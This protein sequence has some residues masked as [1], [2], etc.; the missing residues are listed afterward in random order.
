MDDESGELF[1]KLADFDLAFRRGDTGITYGPMGNIFFLPPEI[2]SDLS[3]H[4]PDILLHYIPVLRSRAEKVDVYALGGV[5]YY[6][7]TNCYPPL[8]E[9]YECTRELQRVISN[10][11]NPWEQEVFKALAYILQN[12]LNPEETLRPSSAEELRDLIQEAYA[13]PGSFR[14]KYSVEFST[15]DIDLQKDKTFSYS[16]LEPLSQLSIKTIMDNLDETCLLVIQDHVIRFATPSL[17]SFTNKS[18]SEFIEN[19]VLPLPERDYQEEFSLAQCEDEI[20][21]SGKK[22]K[23]YSLKLQIGESGL[24]SCRIKGKVVHWN[25]KPAVMFLL[26]DVT[27]EEQLEKQLMQAQKMET[28]G[29]LAG[30]IAH[31]FNNILASIIGYS[32]LLKDEIMSSGSDI[33]KKNIDSILSASDRATELVKQIL[34]FSR[35][36]EPEFKKISLNLLINETT[37]LLR[38]ALPSTIELSLDLS[39]TDLTLKA[40]ATQIHQVLMNIA[41]NAAHAMRQQGGTITLKTKRVDIKKMQKNVPDSK[42]GTY[43]YISV[44]DTGTGMKKEVLTHIFEPYFTTKKAGEGTGMGLAVVHGIVKHHGGWINVDSEVGV[45][46]TFH[47][48]FPLISEE[49]EKKTIET[50]EHFPVIP[51]TILVNEPNED[52]RQAMVIAL[53]QQGHTVFEANYGQEAID[54]ATSQEKPLDLLITASL[55]PGISTK[56]LIDRMREINPD[57]RIL[58]TYSDYRDFKSQGLKENEVELL[59]KPFSLKGLAKKIQEM[60][61]QG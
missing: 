8:G 6:L 26:R 48:Y 32:E 41:T 43:A 54:L 1:P 22:V 40:G 15:G 39:P 21:S 58:Y 46:T 33:A 45:G 11:S 42:P 9:F 53:Q 25:G 24:K 29:T 16:Y 14:D 50:L 60:F 17:G 61:Q 10:V 3:R 36:R 56:K 20:L 27:Q 49:K 57:I 44:S 4:D 28:I 37:K 47:L 55:F 51:V 23:E 59:E 18:M 52:I 12:V 34:T 7:L 5:L 35:R 38:S 31:D 30:G 13:D 19:P 2:R